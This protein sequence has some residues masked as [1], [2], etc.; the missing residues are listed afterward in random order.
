MKRFTVKGYAASELD[1]YH[2][3]MLVTGDDD[4]RSRLASAWTGS[5]VE[6]YD[7]EHADALASIATEWANGLDAEV[8]ADRSGDAEWA[9]QVRAARDG[10]STLAS[11]LRIWAATA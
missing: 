11:K 9:R 1:I 8:D 3:E 2:D 5:A 10:L 7:A 6:V 4:D